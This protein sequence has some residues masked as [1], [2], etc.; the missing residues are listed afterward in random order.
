[1]DLN[2]FPGDEDPANEMCGLLATAFHAC[3]PQLTSLKLSAGNRRAVLDVSAVVGALSQLRSLVIVTDPAL[4]VT[5]SMAAFTALGN[6]EL[7]PRQRLTLGQEVALPPELT[8]LKFRLGGSQATL[9]HQVG[10][11]CRKLA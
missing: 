4:T 2:I 11:M 10:P 6:F 3:G 7:C 1:M 8:S 5:T 9:P